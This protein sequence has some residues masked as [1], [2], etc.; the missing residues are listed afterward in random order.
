MFVESHG[1]TQCGGVCLRFVQ[2]I[3]PNMDLY[4]VY[5]SEIVASQT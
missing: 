1:E 4:K 5:S 2:K 3:L